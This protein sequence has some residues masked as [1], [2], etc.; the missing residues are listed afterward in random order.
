[1]NLSLLFVLV[2]VFGPELTLKFVVSDIGSVLEDGL[3]LGV[4]D[5][6]YAVGHVL[7]FGVDVVPFFNWEIPVVLLI[8]YDVD[9]MVHTAR[10]V[11]LDSGA[12]CLKVL[13]VV[14]LI[15]KDEV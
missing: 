6:G 7:V 11:V 14:S 5:A 8:L 3:V 4:M 12:C 13:I 10:K 9:G 1:L 15:L 2:V